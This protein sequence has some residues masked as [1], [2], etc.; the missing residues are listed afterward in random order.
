MTRSILDELALEGGALRALAREAR[1][2]RLAQDL[3]QAELE[4]GLW[5]EPEPGAV[6]APL[7]RLAAAVDGAERYAVDPPLALE[8]GSRLRVTME[9]TAEGSWVVTAERLR[10]EGAS[11][12]RPA[13][14]VRITGQGSSPAVRLDLPEG[15]DFVSAL[16]SFEPGPAP[17]IEAQL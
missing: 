9:P 8:D 2:V 11:R 6:A 16:V 1:V 12:P 7:L 4:D 14:Q 5:V 17:Q 13:V 3:A 10:G 15:E